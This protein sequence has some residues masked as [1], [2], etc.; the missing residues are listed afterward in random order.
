MPELLCAWISDVFAQHDGR[1]QDVAV[2]RA[3]WCPRSAPCYQ[4]YQQLAF[5]NTAA[6]V[7]WHL[8][9]TLWPQQ[10]GLTETPLLYS[11]LFYWRR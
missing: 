2:T 9:V 7:P 8:L 1:L 4:V 5:V 10:V 11:W 6:F 3:V